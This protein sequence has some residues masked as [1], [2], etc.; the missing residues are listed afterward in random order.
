VTTDTRPTISTQR[1]WRIISA[2]CVDSF[3]ETALSVVREDM[4]N[5]RLLVVTQLGH[6][7]V[8]F[9]KR[10]ESSAMSELVLIDSR[11]QLRDLWPRDA[12]RR[13]ELTTFV[14]CITPTLCAGASINE[15]SRILLFQHRL[16]YDSS[17]I[18]LTEP[19]LGQKMRFGKQFLS[20]RPRPAFYSG[21]TSFCGGFFEFGST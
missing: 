16:H 20:K 11:S 19:T 8:Q 1:I 3:F 17:R 10:D 14:S 6:H 7:V 9:F 15:R 13:A 2:R 21:G 4:A 18:D 5:T 12:D